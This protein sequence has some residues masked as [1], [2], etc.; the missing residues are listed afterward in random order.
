M[1]ANII[2]DSEAQ[3]LDRPFWYIIPEEI[4]LAIGDMVLLPFG[5]LKKAARGFVIELRSDLPPEVAEEKLKT[6]QR[7]LT[8]GLFDETGLQLVHFMRRKYLSTHLEALRLLMPKGSLTGVGHKIR[9]EIRAVMEPSMTDRGFDRYRP[10]Y[11]HVLKH[12]SRGIIRSEIIQAG[13]S[14]SSLQTMIKKGYLAVTEAVDSRYDR[15][16]YQADPDKD[17]FPEQAEA[18]RTITDSPPGVFLIHGITGSGKTEV[19]LRAVAENLKAGHDS[20]ILVPEIALTPQM[21]ERVKGRFGSEITVYHSKLNDGERF[22]E[23]MRVRDKKVKIAIGARSALFLPFADLKMVVID[24]EHETSYKSETNPKYVTREAAEF[25]MAMKGGKVILASATPSMESYEKALRGDCHLIKI[26]RRAGDSHLPKII[27]KDMRDELRQGNYSVLSRD[28]TDAIRENLAKGQQT[29]LFLNRRGVSSF[30]SCRSCGFVYKCRNCSVSL[31]K[32]E[33]G[34]LTC[35]HCGHTEYL[36]GRCPACGSNMIKE[37]GS[38]TEKVEAEIRQKFPAARLIRM[39]RDT[40]AKKDAY[41]TIYNQFRNREADILI[42]TQMVAKGLDFPGVT[43]VGIIAADMSLNMPDFRAYEKTF[44]LITQVSGR[45]G[46]GLDKGLVILQT[47]EPDAYPITTSS[48]ND[49]D[50]F[51]EKES[52]IRQAMG[53]PPYGRLMSV[54]ISS[55]TETELTEFIQSVGEALRDIVKGYDNIG[56]L[57]PVPCLISR[58]KTWYRYQIIIKGDFSDEMALAMKEEIYRKARSRDFKVSLDVNPVTII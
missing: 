17:L 14:A 12:Q 54:V 23:W 40:T 35:H 31:T 38:G 52:G 9:L 58:L 42:G 44:Q 41:E 24:E 3:S 46:R 2:I 48:R 21:I 7:R 4:Q 50:G 16:G 45:A 49:F 30:V 29:I 6:I 53:Y 36:K 11:D 34:R 55:Q 56:V 51:W 26:G 32:H 20:V 1:F 47:Y 19:F 10:I 39:D 25:M 33:G 43:L 57:G 22:D 13:F 15:R 5:T 8:G 28:L 27:T 37:F 18:L